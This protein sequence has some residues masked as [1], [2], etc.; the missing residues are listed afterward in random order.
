MVLTQGQISEFFVT[1]MQLPAETVTK[2]EDEGILHPTD[3]KEFDKEAMARIDGN[4]RKPGDR[5]PNPD[6]GAQA[7]STIPR[8][9]Y[10]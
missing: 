2:L 1:Q 10:I 3:L 4:L 6:P 5:I 7:G 8:P 9:P